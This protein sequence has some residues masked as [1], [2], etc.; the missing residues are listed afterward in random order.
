MGSALRTRLPNVGRLRGVVLFCGGRG[1]VGE[2]V[3][4]IGDGVDC[5][6]TN[7]DCLGND[8]GCSK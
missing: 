4:C 8:V 6:G 5:L 7:S 3:G 2:D 1:C